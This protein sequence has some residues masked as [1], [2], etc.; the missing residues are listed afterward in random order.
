M[1]QGRGHPRPLP[2]ASSNCA[3]RDPF[4]PARPGGGPQSHLCGS[5]AQLS[6]HRR[7]G[8]R[9]LC[10]EQQDAGGGAPAPP[11]DGAGRGISPKQAAENP[12]SFRAPGQSIQLRF[13]H[14]EGGAKE[15]GQ[16]FARSGAWRGAAVTASRGLEAPLGQKPLC[17]RKHTRGQL[18]GFGRRVTAEA[19]CCTAAPATEAC[20][21]PGF[22]ALAVPSLSLGWVSGPGAL[23]EGPRKPLPA[24]P[25][26][27]LR[28]RDRCTG[29]QRRG[30]W[31]GVGEPP[32]RFSR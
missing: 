25:A 10:W 12:G 7:G 24:S 29:K 17:P 22:A 32:C 18:H 5:L 21:P 20:G 11:G 30:L 6:R 23:W 28:L 26:T 2:R 27:G 14:L 8:G 31:C 4:N 13:A 1:W 3:R 16:G 9:V 15:G 19:P